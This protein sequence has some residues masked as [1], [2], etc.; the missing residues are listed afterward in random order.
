MFIAI[1]IGHVRTY[2]YFQTKDKIKDCV[3]SLLAL[4]SLTK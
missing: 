1:S 2:I 3:L 4:A